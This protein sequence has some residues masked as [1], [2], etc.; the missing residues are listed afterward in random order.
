MVVS[1]IPGPEPPRSGDPLTPFSADAR[2][3]DPGS[4]DLSVI[5]SK[6]LALQD[7]LLTLKLNSPPSPS[8]LTT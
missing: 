7:F 1:G 8:H 2:S 3:G 5:T 4:G 6:S